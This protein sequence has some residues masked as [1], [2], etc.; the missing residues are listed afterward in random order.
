[1]TNYN[2]QDLS[3]KRFGRLIAIER[4]E[5]YVLPCGQKHTQWLCKCDCGRYKKI[6]ALSLKSGHCSSCGCY[7]L[8]KRTKHGQYKS[9]LYRIYI[10]MKKRCYDKN[11]KRY[12]DYGGRGITICEEWKNN[13]LSFYSL[14]NESGY[15]DSLTIDRIDNNL[16]YSQL[17]CRW[18]TT[19]EQS[20]N[21]RTSKKIKYNGKEQTVALWSE[22]LHIDKSTLYHRLR[23][24]WT[25]ERAFETPT[26]KTK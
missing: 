1:M 9:R 8:E 18:A 12:N 14:A 21:K 3:G 22:E 15:N 13:F 23:R 10:N 24:G 16:S 5:D 17:N 25:V 7:G 20:N 6:T 26:Y 2:F 19:K 4:V 11:N